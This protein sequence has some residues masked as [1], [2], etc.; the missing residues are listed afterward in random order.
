M[1]AYLEHQAK[2]L[3]SR[4]GIPTTN[5]RLV[6]DAAAAVAYA[7]EC[8]APLAMKVASPGIVH[9]SK[10]GCVRL[11]VAPDAAA[12]VF[13][14]IMA[15]AGAVD[16]ARIEGVIVEPMVAP[17]VEVIIGATH[18]PV[19]GPVI[20]F[21]SGGTDVERIGRVTFRL[22]PLSDRDAR[23]MV[24]AVDVTGSLA[25][26]TAEVAAVEQLIDILLAVGGAKGLVLGEAVA[27]LDINPLII[28]DGGVTAVDAHVVTMTGDV[29]DPDALGIIAPK[30]RKSR[31]AK[32]FKSLRPLFKPEAIVVVG[33][34]TRPM[35]LGFRI[36]QNLVDFG[37][38]GK[39]YAVHPPGQQ[40][41]RLSRL[42][43]R[44]CP[45]GTG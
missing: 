30:R 18:D 29:P 44:R 24:S 27:D 37:F 7:Q 33:A 14:D 45:A 5:P 39:L 28:N 31:Q 8:G 19:F 9:K 12:E 11:D 21:G 22:A 41:L 32:L 38:P 43:I 6:V 25:S 40:H 1:P 36:I 17:G 13:D 26:G 23:A 42:S 20:M 35:K 4:Y 10:A 34:S 3:L 15:A 2:E 16:N